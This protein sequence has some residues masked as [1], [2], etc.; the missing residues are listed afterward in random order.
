MG[1]YLRLRRTTRRRARNEADGDGSR[2]KGPKTKITI[3]ISILWIYC[4]DISN[5]SA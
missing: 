2:L 5:I 3:R 4:I 1:N